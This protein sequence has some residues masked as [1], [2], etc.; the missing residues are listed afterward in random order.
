MKMEFN[1]GGTWYQDGQWTLMMIVPY[2]AESFIY[3]FKKYE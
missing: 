3:S 1:T 2:L